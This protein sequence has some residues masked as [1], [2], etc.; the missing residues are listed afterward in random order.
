MSKLRTE[1]KNKSEKEKASR[2][3]AKNKSIS[4]KEKSRG[5]CHLERKKNSLKRDQNHYTDAKIRVL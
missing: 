1:G 3:K 5:Y 2:I 4:I